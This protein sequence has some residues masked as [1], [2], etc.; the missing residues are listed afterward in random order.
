[1]ILMRI[2]G[3]EHSDFILDESAIS[4]A[5]L[6]SAIDDLRE[7]NSN[8]KAQLFELKRFAGSVTGSPFGGH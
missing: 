7:E 2:E 4:A 3:E 1:M 8:L 6:L 5:E